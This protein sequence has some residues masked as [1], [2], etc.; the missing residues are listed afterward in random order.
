MI[1]TLELPQTNEDR[2]VVEPDMFAR[3]KSMSEDQRKLFFA[4]L[5]QEARRKFQAMIEERRANPYLSFRHDPTN[6]V[7]STAG[8]GEVAWSLQR[9]IMES[10]RDN[11][12]TAV[13]AC[14]APGKSHIAAR[15]IAW[16]GSVHPAGTARILTTATTFRQV[17]NILW[18]YIRN[19]HA[20]HGLPGEMNMVEWYITLG[21]ERHLVAEGVKP[22]DEA[23]ASMSG[24]HAPHVLIVVDEAGGISHSFGRSLLGLLTGSHTRLLII[25]NPPIDD[26]GSW[27]EKQCDRTDLF[28]VIRIPYD[29]TPNATGEHVGY[30]R[31]HP[32]LEPH[33]VNDHLIAQDYVDELVLEYGE[34]SPV[35]IARRDARFPKSNVSKTLPIMWLEAARVFRGP[36]GSL[37]EE[38]P[39]GGEIQVGADIAGGM[40]DELTIAVID[41]GVARMKYA[42][43]DER[44]RDP[45]YVVGVAAEWA[46]WAASEHAARRINKPVRFKVDS[47]GLGWNIYGQLKAMKIPGVQIVEVDAGAVAHNA[48]RFANVRAEMWWAMRQAIE[49]DSNGKQQILLD[50]EWFDG[51]EDR[52]SIA[53]LNAPKYAMDAAGRRILIESKK[54]MAKRGLRS[55]DR[56]DAVLMAWYEPEVVIDV[57]PIGAILVGGGR[58]SATELRSTG[59]TAADSSFVGFSAL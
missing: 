9:S 43:I 23:E 12:R 31:S 21:N 26:E 47:L 33:L 14:H 56:A 57:P 20:A 52:K 10:V 5:T 32:G 51:A 27:F 8:L 29:L 35:V 39:T 59:A 6:F 25:G 46:R 36:D 13:P 17:R 41:T 50:L 37:A 24:V 18:P 1:D 3:L 34:N 15:I 54:D 44:H 40:S 22:P 11:K 49:P 45:Q 16:W 38:I 7:T 53:Q 2:P 30:C 19:V 4:S 48:D 58:S 55:P 28:N 42:Q